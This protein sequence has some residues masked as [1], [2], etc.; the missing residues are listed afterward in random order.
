V[1]V[2]LQKLKKGG[3]NKS[4]IQHNKIRHQQK[5]SECGVY[6]INFILRLLKGETFDEIT[7]NIT[8]DEEV[9]KCRKVYFT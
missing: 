2:T 7:N 8:L 3:S 4:D 6:S 9:N 5:G 1:N